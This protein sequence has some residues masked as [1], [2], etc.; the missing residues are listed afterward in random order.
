MNQGGFANIILVVAI[1][2]IIA[3]AGYFVLIKKSEQIAPQPASPTT[4]APTQPSKTQT[5][6]EDGMGGGECPTGL[7]APGEYYVRAVDKTGAD[8]IAVVSPNGG[9]QWILNDDNYQYIKWVTNGGSGLKDPTSV[10]LYLDK[11]EGGNFITVGQVVPFSRGSV[12]WI[13][14][15]VY[16]PSTQANCLW[17]TYTKEKQDRSNAPFKIVTP[18]AVKE[19]TIL[20]PKNGDKTVKEF[21]FEN[22]FYSSLPI[23][24]Y[25]PSRL[26]GQTVNII[27]ELI[28]PNGKVVEQIAPNEQFSIRPLVY[29]LE[30]PTDFKYR[31]AWDVYASPGDYKIRVTIKVSSTGEDLKAESGIFSIILK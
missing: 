11:K 17:P 26:V 4:S 9:E 24:W 14:G 28:D 21:Y 31:K 12:G 8:S 30:V 23:S 16:F 29:T 18:P 6:S 7:V 5:I 3:V 19:L 27:I 22:K 13:V 1:I 20:E 2:A 25:Y 15:F 10:D